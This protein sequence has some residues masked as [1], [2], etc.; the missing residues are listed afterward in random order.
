MYS[1]N[2]LEKVS[3]EQNWDRK[4]PTSQFNRLSEG[5]NNPGLDPSCCSSILH[6]Q[7]IFVKE[8]FS[9]HLNSSSNL[10][11]PK[12]YTIYID[13]NVNNEE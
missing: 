10:Y 8:Y 2:S 9:Y 11:P 13:L 3:N 4:N 5:K 1:E 6:L 7:N 12:I